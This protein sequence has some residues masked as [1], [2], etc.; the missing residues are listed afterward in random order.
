MIY[1][2]LTMKAMKIAFAV[3]KD[4]VDKAGVPY[5]YHPIHLAESMDDEYSIVVALLHDVVEDSEMTFADLIESGFPN[6][7]ITAL[8][9]L[10][11]SPDGD[12]LDYIELISKNELATKVKLADIKHNSDV[13]RLITVT[14]KDLER[15]EK[16]KKAVEILRGTVL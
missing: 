7:V 13:T 2:D 3:H 5:I 6:E 12:Y 14:D 1:T 15:F 9:L 16:Y 4:Q 10:T 8:K 11:H